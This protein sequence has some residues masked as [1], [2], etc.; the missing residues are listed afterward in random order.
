MHPRRSQAQIKATTSKGRHTYTPFALR[1]VTGTHL[2]ILAGVGGN[3]DSKRRQTAREREERQSTYD[4]D[5]D[6]YGNKHILQTRQMRHIQSPPDFREGHTAS[7]V[8]ERPHMTRN[9]V[10][11]VIIVA[12][13]NFHGSATGSRYLLTSGFTLR[14]AMSFSLKILSNFEYLEHTPNK[15]RLASF[16]L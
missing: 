6:N 16:L 1:L 14:V 5:V 8:T 4:T 9:G 13:R 12:E 7:R 11:A 10:V 2:R 15:S 3:K